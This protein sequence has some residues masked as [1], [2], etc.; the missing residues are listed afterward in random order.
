MKERSSKKG[1]RGRVWILREQRRN[2][3][4]HITVGKLNMRGKKK[5]RECS[6]ARSNRTL[7]SVELRRSE[8]GRSPS[9]LVRCNRCNRQTVRP[10]VSCISSLDYT[11]LQFDKH[12]RTHACL[13]SAPC[14]GMD[15]PSARYRRGTPSGTQQSMSIPPGS[16]AQFCT[17]R[18]ITIYPRCIEGDST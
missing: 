10:P 9:V 18:G 15:L 12:T 8:I 2:S 3:N 7:P 13:K 5:R 4:D 11:R 17:S 1:R 14:Y 16:E 6:M